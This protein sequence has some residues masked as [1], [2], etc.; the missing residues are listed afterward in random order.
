MVTLVFVGFARAKLENTYMV[1]TNTRALYIA[2]Q[3]RPIYIIVDNIALVNS[4]NV[5]TAAFTALIVNV[6]LSFCV[7]SILNIALILTFSH[8]RL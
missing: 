4:P 3:I 8:R 2:T 5:I 6:D 7:I 1:I